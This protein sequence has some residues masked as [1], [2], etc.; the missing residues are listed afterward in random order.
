MKKLNTKKILITFILVFITSSCNTS[1][2]TFLLRGTFACNEL[3]LG[4]MVFDPENDY[5]FYYYY[6][7]LQGNGRLDKGTFLRKSESQ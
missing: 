2:K 3:P 7:D 5:T 4:S 1:N 6:A